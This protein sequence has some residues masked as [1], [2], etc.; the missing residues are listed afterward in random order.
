MLYRNNEDV[1]WIIDSNC[2][3]VRI[4]SSLFKT[5]DARDILTID[6]TPYFKRQVINQIAPSN[7]T[8]SFSSNTAYIDD[9]FILNWNCDEKLGGL[10]QPSPCIN[11]TCGNLDSIFSCI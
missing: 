3:T 2:N 6:E 7:F 4:I 1:K 11:E 10:L 8:V 5:Y 9:G